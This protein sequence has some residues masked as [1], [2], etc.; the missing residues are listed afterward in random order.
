MVGLARLELDQNELGAN[1]SAAVGT[2][3][4]EEDDPR[5]VAGGA[6]SVSRCVISLPPLSSSPSSPCGALVA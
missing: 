4:E 3:G 6:S 5:G 2:V 1:N